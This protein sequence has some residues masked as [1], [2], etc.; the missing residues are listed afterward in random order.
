MQEKPK[1]KKTKIKTRSVSPRWKQAA[2]L[3]TKKAIAKP[4]P[5]QQVHQYQGYQPKQ[6]MYEQSESVKP[7]AIA[8]KLV[9]ERPPPQ[10]QHEYVSRVEPVHQSYDVPVGRQ[11]PALAKYVPPVWDE[12]ESDFAEEEIEAGVSAPE[13]QE[14]Y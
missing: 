5:W 14:A 6:N 9:G 1:K 4:K 11:K 10:I 7:K 3:K 8:E 2:E 13:I 12:E